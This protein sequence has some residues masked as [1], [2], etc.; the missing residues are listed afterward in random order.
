[1]TGNPDISN[2]LLKKISLE[3]SFRDKKQLLFAYN[4]F[5]KEDYETFSHHLKQIKR[6]DL[7]MLKQTCSLKGLQ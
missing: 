7:G 6:K 3:K 4:Y 5:I 1:M 2:H